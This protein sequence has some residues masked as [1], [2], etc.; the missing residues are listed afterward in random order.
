MM[1]LF[2]IIRQVRNSSKDNFVIK[3][4]FTLGSCDEELFHA[5][6]TNRKLHYKK[7]SKESATDS[8]NDSDYSQCQNNSSGTSV[9]KVGSDNPAE[10]NIKEEV[11]QAVGNDVDNYEEDEGSIEEDVNEDDEVEIIQSSKGR[12]MQPRTNKLRVI[13]PIA[14]KAPSRL[15]R[16]KSK[17]KDEPRKMY[18]QLSIK[19]R[20]MGCSRCH[21]S[22]HNITRCQHPA[23]EV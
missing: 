14:H 17:D 8:D 7:G 2:L 21:Q 18:G 3:D 10:G 19:G 9:C 20:E 11:N 6:E 5:K 12:N 22:G 16:I 1:H 13:P 4:E 15:K 23:S